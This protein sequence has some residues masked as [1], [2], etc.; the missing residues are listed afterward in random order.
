ME[1]I[2]KKGRIFAFIAA[3]IFLINLFPV[4]AKN[5]N[6]VIID[7]V[8]A[9]V[10]KTPI[11]LYDFAK[12]NRQAFEEYEQM[13]NNASQGIFTSSDSLI[14]SKT[15]GVINLLA[16][17]ILLKQEEERAAIYV[18]PKQ[19]GGYIKD[20]AHANNFTEN[21][22]FDFLKKRGISKEA[23]IKRV[24]AHFIQMELLRKVY[25]NK[26]IITQKEMQDY[27]KKNIE[28]FRGMPMADLKL[29]FLA[30]PRNASKE[31]KKKIYE[32]ML[33]IR[34]LAINGD[35]GFSSLARTYSEDPSEKNG[36]RIGYVYKDKLSPNFSK[37]AFRLKV[38]QISRVIKS[39]FGY[40]IFKSVGK[41]MG[42][43]KTF[44]QVKPEIFSILEKHKT[45][46][47]LARLL[48]RARKNAYIKIKIP[49]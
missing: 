3:S 10:N 31:A 49:V 38:G 35:T 40:T 5:A 37:I 6:A 19:L 34:K 24:R 7:Q 28:E 1:S 20:V 23:Y 29:I 9:V 48:K 42:A 18:S 46:E 33:K 36:G 32:K 39:P 27:Y 15:K 41:K 2:I 30:V 43:F 16:D 13:Q 26:M 12:F 22:F 47:Y 11:T 45:N 21:Q 44:K 4:S 17:N 8:I 25:G 14:M